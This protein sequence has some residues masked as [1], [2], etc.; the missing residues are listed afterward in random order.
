MYYRLLVRHSIRYY[1]YHAI[2][3]RKV[4]CASRGGVGYSNGVITLIG[5]EWTLGVTLEL[6]TV[7][8]ENHFFN[9][10]KYGTV[11][12]ENIMLGLSAMT[13]CAPDDLVLNQGPKAKR[14]PVIRLGR[15]TSGHPRSLS[16]P[17]KQP[18]L[19][20]RC[21]KWLHQDATLCSRLTVHTRR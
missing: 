12:R 2:P 11:F 13:S 18:C 4:A 9:N 16:L 1:W 5:R 15:S 20:S 8:Q 19:K 6:S 21:V 7:P 10:E 3:G 14:K 17:E